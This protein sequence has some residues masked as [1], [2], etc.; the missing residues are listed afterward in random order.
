MNTIWRQLEAAKFLSTCESNDKFTVRDL[1][2][3]EI[4]NENEVP[5]LFDGNAERS[6]LVKMII[7]LG[8]NIS[9]GFGIAFR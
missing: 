4:T 3:G 9:E 2:P 8:K 6:V 7:L 1:F 5:T